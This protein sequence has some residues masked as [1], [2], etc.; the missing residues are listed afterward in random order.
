MGRDAVVKVWGAEEA[1]INIFTI[2][3]HGPVEHYKV[4]FRLCFIG[5][6]HAFNMVGAHDLV[7]PARR[8]WRNEQHMCSAL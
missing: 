1:K 2:N 7:G 5:W 8:L 6:L 4:W 3:R